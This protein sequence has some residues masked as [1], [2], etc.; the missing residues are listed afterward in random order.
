MSASAHATMPEPRQTFL[1]EDASCEQLLR[2]AASNHRQS[3]I[4]S[5]RERGGEVFRENGAT[6]IYTPGPIGEVTISF[7]RLTPDVASEQI[8]TIMRYCR[9]H[10]PLRS[11]S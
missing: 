7:P 4:R 10:R 2:A 9:R 3:W 11:V 5:A 8:D 6:W 1:E